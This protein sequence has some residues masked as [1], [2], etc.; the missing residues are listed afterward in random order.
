[1]DRKSSPCLDSGDSRYL[2]YTS[3]GVR[4]KL[5]RDANTQL[6]QAEEMAARMQFNFIESDD[7]NKSAFEKLVQDIYEFEA[8]IKKISP[9]DP[10]QH[11]QLN[12]GSGKKYEDGYTNLSLWEKIHF[13]VGCVINISRNA[14]RYGLALIANLQRR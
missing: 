2:P 10:N 11:L 6:K 14:T 9:L 13:L 4:E 5:P 12:F 3:K 1:M 8:L 7:I